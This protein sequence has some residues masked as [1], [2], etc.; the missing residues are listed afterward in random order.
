MQLLLNIT[1]LILRDL[2]YSK[3]LLSAFNSNW[4]IWLN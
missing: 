3:E 2:E 1:E 4:Y